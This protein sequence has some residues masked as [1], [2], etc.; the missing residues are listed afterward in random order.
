MDGGVCPTDGTPLQYDPWS[1]TEHR[2]PTCR[3]AQRGERHYRWWAKWQHLWLAERA[4][5][6]AALQAL[7]G[8]DAAGARAGEILSTYAARYWRYPNR[9]NVL[10]P[11]RLF[12][13]T[14]LESLWILNYL[15]AAML[16]RGSGHLD[17]ATTK[18]VTQVADE[19][20]NLIGDFHEGYSNRQTWNNAALAAIAVWFED[21]ELAEGAIGAG[22][23]LI[24]HR[25]LPSVRSAGAT[26]RGVV[27]G[28]GWSR[29]L[30]RPAAR[31]ASC[32]GVAC[33]GP[34][35]PP[36]LHLSRAQGLALRSVPGA[37]DVS[38]YV[39]GGPGPAR[40]QAAGSREQVRHTRVVARST[41]SSSRHQT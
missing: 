1:P 11:S 27:G 31:P 23:G 8:N 14:Y 26:H 3:S 6:L 25:E 34:H 4:A 28:P 20:A 40:E 12:F 24:D 37:T 5:H 15:A 19:A 38:G 29:F 22:G 10:G 17:G 2:C 33:S 41:L 13:S 35:R 32:G 7:A 36:G 39:G 16:L 9:D 30:L 21:K 18:G